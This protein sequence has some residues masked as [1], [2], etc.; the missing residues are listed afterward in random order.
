MDPLAGSES[1]VGTE[2]ATCLEQACDALQRVAEVMDP[3]ARVWRS[4]VMPT[5]QQGIKVL[6][7]PV[8]HDASVG[9]LEKVQAKQQ[10]LSQTCSQRGFFSSI[11]LQRAP[12][13]RPGLQSSR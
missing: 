12:I 9:C 6:G 7:T 5:D 8:G 10:V 4:E 13:I 2:Q 11:A 1:M 3:R